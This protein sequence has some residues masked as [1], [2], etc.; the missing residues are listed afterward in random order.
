[1]PSRRVQPEHGSARCAAKTK[2]GTR[3]QYTSRL[4]L[5]TD[6]PYKGKYL[7]FA[8]DP[9]RKNVARA[10][11]RKGGKTSQRRKR[12]PATVPP[13]PKTLK[14][15]TDLAAWISHAILAGHID[16]K[17]GAEATK[18][19]SAFMRGLEKLELEQEFRE[20]QKTVKK[21]KKERGSA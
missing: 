19:V 3:C 20:L 1:M 17:R 21:L 6:G 8:H 5:Q 16:A 15:A 9:A 14:E 10:M 11:R 7:C 18:A 12:N 4:A 13:A 2:R